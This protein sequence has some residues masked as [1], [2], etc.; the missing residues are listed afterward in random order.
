MKKK[1]IITIFWLAVWEIASRCINNQIL[2]AGP[3]DTVKALYEMSKEK[4]FYLSLKNSFVN[5]SLGIILGCAAGVILASLSAG[6]SLVGEVLSPFIK[7]IKAIPVA[8]FVVMMLL[9]FG[10][11]KLSLVI[12]ALITMPIFYLSFLEGIRSVDKKMLEMADVFKMGRIS[13]IR[14]IYLPSLRPVVF[15]SASL[16]IG[17]GWRSGAAA[18]VIGQPL[19]TMGNGLYRA[20]ISLETDR[21]FAWT[22]MIILVSVLSEKAFRLLAGLL[23]GNNGKKS[24]KKI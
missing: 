15:S 24:D 7:V 9:W 14:Y 1:L 21:L 18:E 11:K 23:Y 6:V 8:S 12:A 13:R 10:N 16:A 22:F 5:I 19:K 4:D 2:I 20:K 3:W 17:M